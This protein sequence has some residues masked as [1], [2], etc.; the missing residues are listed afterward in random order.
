[1]EIFFAVILISSGHSICDAHFGQGKSN[2]KKTLGVSVSPKD[3]ENQLI[4]SFGELTNTN[5]G[6]YNIII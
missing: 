4:E 1:M 6:K 5:K 2:F 3:G